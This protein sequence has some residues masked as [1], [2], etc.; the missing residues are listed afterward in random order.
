MNYSWGNG[1][2]GTTLTNSYYGQGTGAVL[3]DRVSC[4]GCESA[5]LGCPNA[6]IGVTSCTHANDASVQCLG[7]V[8]QLL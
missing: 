7:K 3:L 2:G 1:T 4:S 8:I 6:G 5:L